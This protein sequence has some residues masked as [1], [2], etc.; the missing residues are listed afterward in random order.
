[1]TLPFSYNEKS[2]S[3]GNVKRPKTKWE[4]MCSVKKAQQLLDDLEEVVRLI[5]D[6]CGYAN[7]E[8]GILTLS[9]YEKKPN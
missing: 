1:M 5:N 2:P 8:L 3:R 7:P 9:I 4:N 6:R